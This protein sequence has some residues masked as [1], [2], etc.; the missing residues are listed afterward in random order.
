MRLYFKLLTAFDRSASVLVIA[1]ANSFAVLKARICASNSL[2]NAYPVLALRI[3]LNG[4]RPFVAET[5]EMQL[6]VNL[7]RAHALCNNN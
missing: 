6:A 1:S 7:L 2:V 3:N 4:A 5:Q